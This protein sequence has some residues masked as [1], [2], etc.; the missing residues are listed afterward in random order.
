MGLWQRDFRCDS[1]STV[2]ARLYSV[3]GLLVYSHGGCCLADIHLSSH[4]ALFS[5]SESSNRKSLGK[6]SYKIKCTCCEKAKGNDFS[7][8]NAASFLAFKIASSSSSVRGQSLQ[9]S[10][11]QLPSL[12]CQYHKLHHKSQSK[13]LNSLLSNS[14]KEEEE[15][16]EEERRYFYS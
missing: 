14:I 7:R 12:D 16:E 13:K 5:M 15:E 9:S 11:T 3:E 10:V 1:I 2:L 4:F 8:T 6:N